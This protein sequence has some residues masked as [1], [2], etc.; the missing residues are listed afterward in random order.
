MS[1]SEKQKFKKSIK[2]RRKRKSAKIDRKNKVEKLKEEF[3]K[4][5]QEKIQGLLPKEELERFQATKELMDEANNIEQ[6]EIVTDEKELRKKSKPV[7]EIDEDFLEKMVITLLKQ[8]TSIGLSAVQVGRPEQYIVIKWHGEMLAFINPEIV[9]KYKQEDAFKEG[10]L[11]VPGKEVTIFR[12]KKITI[13]FKNVF[14][15]QNDGIVFD[16][17]LARVIQH[18]CDHLNG[19]LISDYEDKN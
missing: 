14:G 6:L 13:N 8:P 5:F 2:D 17:M 16:G 9:S 1:K 4:K 11:S 18:E 10:C 19:V 7:D 3:V 15:D 12:P